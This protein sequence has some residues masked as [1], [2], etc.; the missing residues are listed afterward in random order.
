AAIEPEEL[1][2]EPL[3]PPAPLPVIEPAPAAS[4][5]SSAPPPLK[6]ARP[7]AEPRSRIPSLAPVSLPSVAAE[8]DKPRG[9]APWIAT[10]VALAAAAG[11]IIWTSARGAQQAPVHAAHAGKPHGGPDG[12]SAPKAAPAPAPAAANP[13]ASDLL[14]QLA[15]D[16][17]H[18]APVAPTP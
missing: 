16:P 18:P 13:K 9:K 2:L 3:P 8:R 15:L 6:S 5:T 10:G 11:L 17:E 7:T 1:E 12:Q 14:P 4:A